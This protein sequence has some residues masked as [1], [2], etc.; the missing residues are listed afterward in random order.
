MYAFSIMHLLPVE[1]RE[2]ISFLEEIRD[3]LDR[4]GHLK[5]EKNPEGEVLH[6]DFEDFTVHIERNYCKKFVDYRLSKNGELLCE[7]HINVSMQVIPEVYI[8]PLYFLEIPS[9]VSELK[10]FLQKLDVEHYTE[11]GNLL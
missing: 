11:E 3:R 7:V 5:K 6:A 2:V 4:L 1:D 10:R 9:L 8:Q